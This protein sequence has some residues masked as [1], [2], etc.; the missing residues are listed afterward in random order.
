MDI[1]KYEG[2]T[3]VANRDISDSPLADVDCSAKKGD[4]GYVCEA[5]EC[6]GLLF[7][8]FGLGTIAVVPNEIT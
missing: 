2:T 8:D 6:D 1:N 3:V 7:V 4:C 5:I